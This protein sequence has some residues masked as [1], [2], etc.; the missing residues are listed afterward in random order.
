MNK[1]I[2]ISNFPMSYFLSL[3]TIKF[4]IY[5]EAFKK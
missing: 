4:Y 1:K 5:N 3:L 2:N